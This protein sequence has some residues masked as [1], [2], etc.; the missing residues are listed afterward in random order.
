VLVLRILIFWGV[1]LGGRVYR[2]HYFK[3][4]LTMDPTTHEDEGIKIPS[5][6]Q[7]L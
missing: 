1:T 4:I 3:R 5:K 7:Y 2:L 6:H